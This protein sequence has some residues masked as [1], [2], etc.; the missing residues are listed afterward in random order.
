[1]PPHLS[2]APKP[3]AGPRDAGGPRVLQVGERLGRY[4]VEKRCAVEKEDYDRAKEKKHQMERFRGQVYEQLRLH[5]LVDAELVGVRGSPALG[6]AH[7]QGALV[8]RGRPSW[9]GD[10]APCRLRASRCACWGFPRSLCLPPPLVHVRAPAL[11]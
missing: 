3:A 11:F 5:S 6:S 10:R 9:S 4:E 1:M 7:R 8:R 2:L